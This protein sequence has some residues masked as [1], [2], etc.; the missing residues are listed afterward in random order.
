LT[1]GKA[2][3]QAEKGGKAKKESSHEL[4]DGRLRRLYNRQ[5]SFFFFDD[6][7]AF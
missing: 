7:R 4:P 5:Q 2:R 1:R 6:L 3:R